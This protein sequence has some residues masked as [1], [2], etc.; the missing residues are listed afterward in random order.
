MVQGVDALR[1]LMILVNR[2]RDYA[3]TIPV[4]PQ[5]IMNMVDNDPGKLQ[6]IL[7][8]AKQIEPNSTVGEDMGPKFVNKLARQWTKLDTHLSNKDFGA[9]KAYFQNEKRYSKLTLDQQQ[10]LESMHFEEEEF[11]EGGDGKWI[12]P[13]RRPR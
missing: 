8:Y 6:N 9:I 5:E 10:L 3:G 2:S 11:V 7:D 12:F 13:A 4:T 1:E